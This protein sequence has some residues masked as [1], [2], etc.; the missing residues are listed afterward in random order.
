MRQCPAGAVRV[1]DNAPY[2]GRLAQALTGVAEAVEAARIKN[3]ILLSGNWTQDS[4]AERWFRKFLSLGF[5]PPLTAENLAAFLREENA[6]SDRPAGDPVFFAQMAGC[7]DDFARVLLG[8]TSPPDGDTD[9]PPTEAARNPNQ[10]LVL[11]AQARAAAERREANS[12]RHRQEWENY[13]RCRDAANAVNRAVEEYWTA[14]VRANGDRFGMGRDGS[15]LDT[16]LHAANLTRLLGDFA[17]AAR[18][19]GW[20]GRLSQI[21]RERILRRYPSPGMDPEQNAVA[22]DYATRLLDD[23]SAGHLVLRHVSDALTDEAL[24]GVLHWLSLICRGVAGTL[25]FEWAGQPAARHDPGPPTGWRGNWPGPVETVADVVAWI[26]DQIDIR[27]RARGVSAIWC[28][29]GTLLRNAYCLARRLRLTGLPPEPTGT[30]TPDD[31]LT[32]LRNLQMA[33]DARSPAG[34]TKASG[35][36]LGDGVAGANEQQTGVSGLVSEDLSLPPELRGKI[37]EVRRAVEELRGVTQG[38]ERWVLTAGRMIEAMP[39]Y[40]GDSHTPPHLIKGMGDAIQLKKRARLALRTLYGHGCVLP[41]LRGLSPDDALAI[42]PAYPE[43][44]IDSESDKQFVSAAR[45]TLPAL[46][47]IDAELARCLEQIEFAPLSV[48]NASLHPPPKVGTNDPGTPANGAVQKASSDAELKLP[49]EQA[50]STPRNRGELLRQL[51]PADLKAYLSFSFAESKKGKRL[52]DPEAYE[53]LKEEGIPKDAGNLGD[54]A[55]YC[56][57]SFDTWTRYLRNARILLGEQKY[58]RR[59]GRSTGKSII[60]GD[61]IEYQK[62]GDE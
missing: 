43:G 19:A 18:T 57:P 21:D 58:T 33:L 34:T 44:A 5:S 9:Q 17:A 53:L 16:E 10:F 52:E 8:G 55:D 37:G 48:V 61:Q 40:G 59:G 12:K 49:P 35:E 41:P 60:Q 56:L 46:R 38:W 1:E 23:A 50:D 13:E 3:D 47:E 42:F 31:E 29:D 6:E 26:D 32:C 39:P 51:S 54:L 14:Y 24:S 4:Y 27:E 2:V 45:Q 22:F 28:T 20:A 25:A 11:R 36:D 15:T 62:G 30:P 7:A